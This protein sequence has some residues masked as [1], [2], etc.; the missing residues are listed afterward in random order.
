V[1]KK[2]N[3]RKYWNIFGLLLVVALAVTESSSAAPGTITFN[4]SGTC[5][6]CQG[7]ATAT[8]VLVGSYVQ[9]TPIT[10]SNLVSFT[11]NGTNLTGPFTYTPSTPSFFVSGSM[12]NIPGAN[13]F[14][15]V[16]NNNIFFDSELNGN[17][18]VG[19]TDLGTAGT[20]SLAGGGVSPTP[21]PPTSILILMG[22]MSLA[23]FHVW[24]RRRRIA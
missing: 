14:D 11:Y 18:S 22:L 1:N 19:L 16:A 8:L 20:W 17:W 4:F 12:T 23:A 10:A 3:M 21:A 6:D 7:T 15:V 2:G 24:Q 9:G 5:T 13:A